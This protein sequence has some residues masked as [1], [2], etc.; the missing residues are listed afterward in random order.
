MIP[1]PTCHRHVRASDP[2]CPFCHAVL[3]ST[4][5]PH[6]S[7]LATMAFAL[8][9]FACKSAEEGEGTDEAHETTSS[10]SESG[11]SESG[12]SESSTSESGTSETSTESEGTETTTE[13]TDSGG[14][15]FYA[16][17]DP[18]LPP[19]GAEPEV[20]YD[21]PQPHLPIMPNHGARYRFSN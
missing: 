17:P 1:C 13:T 15:S 9:G 20:L 3:Q 2:T 6:A 16:G 4:S 8:L 11:T 14:G 18:D 19:D 10:G 21:G 7:M 12:T 5:A